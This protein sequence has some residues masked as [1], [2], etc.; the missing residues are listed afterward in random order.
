MKKQ[1]W[2]KEF[3]ELYLGSI[4]KVVKNTLTFGKPYEQIKE[5]NEK[6]YQEVLEFVSNLRN[7]TKNKN[8]V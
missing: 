8:L 1:E 6:V 5:E 3:E 7:E 2:E 4:T